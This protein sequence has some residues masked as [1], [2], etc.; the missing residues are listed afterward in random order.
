MRLEAVRHVFNVCLD[1]TLKRLDLMRQSKRAEAC[2]DEDA[3]RAALDA[4]LEK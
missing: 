1:E 3:V 2:R 4:S